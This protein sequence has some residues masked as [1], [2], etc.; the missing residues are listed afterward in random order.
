MTPNDY[1]YFLYS[2]NFPATLPPGYDGTGTP[3]LNNIVWGQGSSYRFT[4]YG[5][6]F[7]TGFTSKGLVAKFVLPFFYAKAVTG[8]PVLTIAAQNGVGGG[9]TF[10]AWM[11]SDASASGSSYELG[12]V[13]AN[14][15]GTIPLPL[16]QPSDFNIYPIQYL[17][18]YFRANRTTTESEDMTISLAGVALNLADQ[19]PSLSGG[20]YTALTLGGATV[21]TI[22]PGGATVT[23]DSSGNLSLGGL[24]EP[25]PSSGYSMG[26]D[27]TIPDAL[28]QL[29][30][31]TQSYLRFSM[32][33]VDTST[34]IVGRMTVGAANATTGEFI[35][36][37]SWYPNNL[38]S[39]LG[40]MNEFFLSLPS[41]AGGGVTLT[42][43]IDSG[44]AVNG[45]KIKAGI[46]I[47]TLPEF[48]ADLYYAAELV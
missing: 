36:G 39:S 8:T 14:A 25:V 29:A 16:D 3:G 32:I 34:D 24:A 48:W 26:F 11:L 10:E 21:G 12:S 27:L 17:G 19:R 5:D 13:T 23:S 43:Q 37:V 6:I 30:V 40:D 15:I 38:S 9:P 33:N 4:G 22:S 41:Y 18:A 44:A 35:D 28:M 45:A 7:G 47:G 31:P 2:S 20:S 1:G 42:I 46:Y